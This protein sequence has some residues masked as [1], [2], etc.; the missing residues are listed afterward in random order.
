MLL[1]VRGSQSQE[2]VEAVVD[3][4]FNGYLTLPTPLIEAL[5]LRPLRRGLAILA[6]GSGISFDIHKAVVEW[7]GYPRRIAVSAADT[8]PL[9]GMS[10][11]HGYELTVQIVDGGSVFI[12]TF[13]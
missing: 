3:T 9:V 1:T 11:L 4:G 5:G 12:R 10:L 13:A 2:E 6:D 8:D 7:D